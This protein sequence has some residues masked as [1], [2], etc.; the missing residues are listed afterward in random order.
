MSRGLR[1]FVTGASGQDGSYLTEQLLA[2]GAEVHALATPDEP[3]PAVDGVEV[4]VGD[5]LD[6]ERVRDLVTQV[7][8]DE[9]YNLAALSSVARS[10]ERPDVTARLNGT[11]A[12]AL[13]ESAWQLQQ[14]TGRVVRFV[15]ASSAEIFGEP[16]RAPQD[17]HTPIRPLNPYGAAKS[18]AHLS[19]HVYRQRGLHATS[20]I[21]Y[22]HESPRRPR[23]FVTR[24]ITSTVAEIA[25]GRAETLTL[26]NLDARRDWGWAPDYVDAM[27][28]AARAEMASDF[29]IATGV[30]HSVRDFAAAAFSHAG[31]TDWEDRL[32]VDEAFVRPADAT[33]LVGD[34]SRARR[35]LDWAPTVAFEDLVG[36]MVDADLGSL[37]G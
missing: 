24:K 7:A 4:H 18:F 8:P 1:A 20:V 2:A 33:E 6:V 11:A 5:L 26:G 15:Q 36:R 16:D 14:R 10:W 22:N 12:A 13:M 3:V 31:V 37:S 35:L 27:V 23:Q 34:A 32:L 30:G 29:V 21:L 17:E 9:V 28:R 25:L 19:A